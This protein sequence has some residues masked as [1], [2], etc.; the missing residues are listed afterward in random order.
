MGLQ[1][2]D[3]ANLGSVSEILNPSC[4]DWGHVTFAGVLPAPP[5]SEVVTGT[6]YV[7][8]KSQ[9]VYVS[10]PIYAVLVTETTLR[11]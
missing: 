11:F 1:I 3:C 5:P 8:F 6:M 9:D 4:P 7:F 2:W 10:L